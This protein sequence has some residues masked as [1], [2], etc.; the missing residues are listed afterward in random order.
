VSFAHKLIGEATTINGRVD[1]G[2]G[3]VIV[4]RRKLPNRLF[5]SLLLAVE[6]KS[7]D[8][9]ETALPQLVVYLGCLRQAR[10]ARGRNDCSVYGVTSDGF[11]FIFVMITHEGVLRTSRRFNIQQGDLK[12]VMGCLVYI[13]RKTA[14]MSPTT[15]PEKTTGQKSSVDETE[16][17]ADVAFDLGNNKFLHSADENEDEDE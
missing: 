17:T 14:D 10:M 6:A 16:D 9:V 12:T 1:H 11:C 7:K 15:M 4:S 5:Y 8:N 3:I 2:I 13:L